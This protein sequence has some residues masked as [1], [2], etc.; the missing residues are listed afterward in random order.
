MSTIAAVALAALSNTAE[1]TSTNIRSG[2]AFDNIKATWNQALNLGDFSTKL[3]CNYDYKDNKD[4]LKDCSLSG[5]LMEA[6]SDD[7]VRVSYEVSHNFGDKKTN[8]KLSANTRGTTLGAE[9]DDRELK[10]VS[11]VRDVDVGDQS[12]NTEASWLVKAQTARVKLMS[13]LRGSDRVKAQI[14]FNP[15]DNSASYELGYEHQLEQGRDVSAT[16]NPGDKN[17]DVELVDNKFES[18]ATWTA[19]AS[20]PLDNAGSNNIL[21]AA[22]LT[23]KRSWNW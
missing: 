13:N 3:K 17:L 4:F 2:A 7:D 12:I 22:K 20:V 10:E 11:A 9:V 23:L 19:K 5:D 16:F 1:I 15:N 18:G 6:S 14:D 21:D 8:L